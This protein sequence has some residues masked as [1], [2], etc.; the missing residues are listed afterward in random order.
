MVLRGVAAG[1]L[2]AAKGL[3]RAKGCKEMPRLVTALSARDAHW[4]SGIRR[5]GASTQ[6][7]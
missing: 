5:K 7:T 3:R 4:V 1:V 6:P 2:E